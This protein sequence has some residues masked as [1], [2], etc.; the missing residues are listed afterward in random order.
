MSQIDVVF[1]PGHDYC[2]QHV[3]LIDIS[4]THKQVNAFKNDYTKA[5]ISNF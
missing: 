3:Y 4:W 2:Q 5:S 1:N